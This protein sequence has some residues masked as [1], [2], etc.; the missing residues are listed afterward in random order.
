MAEQDEQVVGPDGEAPEPES[1]CDLNVDLDAEDF[2]LLSLGCGIASVAFGTFGWLR[3]WIH[4]LAIPLGLLAIWAGYTALKRD[5][6]FG[7][8][9]MSGLGAGS[10]GLAMFVITAALQVVLAVLR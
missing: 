4:F 5:T 1:C 10:L 8:A 6:K 3:A 9:A 2:A 7:A